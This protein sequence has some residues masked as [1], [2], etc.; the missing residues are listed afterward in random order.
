MLTTLALKAR[1]SMHVTY[2]IKAG[3]AFETGSAYTTKDG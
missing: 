1:V 2:C 3:L